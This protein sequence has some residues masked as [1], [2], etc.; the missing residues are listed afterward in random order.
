MSDVDVD[1]VKLTFRISNYMQYNLDDF[2]RSVSKADTLAHLAF[3]VFDASSD[4]M[5]GRVTIQ[6]RGAAGYGTFSVELPKG[7]Y[8]VI[9]LGYD[10][11][12]QCHIEAPDR[13]FFDDN[14]VPHTFLYSKEITVDGSLPSS[15]QVVLHRCVSAFRINIDD[16]LPS[17]LASFRMSCKQGGVVLNGKTGYVDADNSV[18]RSHSINIPSSYLGTKGMV[19]LTAYLFLPSDQLELDYVV[20]ALDVKG[21]VIKSRTFEAVPMQINVLAN[22]TGEF[23]SGDTPMPPSDSEASFGIGVDTEWKQTLEM[24]Y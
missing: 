21:N 24:T 9:F 15:Q 20:D 23:F 5:I 7:K 10:G 12:R 13:I 19:Y 4:A 8:R 2:T 6:N 22:F 3:A 18:G 17:N 1:D 11:T 14:Y 16:V